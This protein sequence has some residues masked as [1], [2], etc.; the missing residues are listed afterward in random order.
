M[1]MIRR[2]LTLSA[3]VLAAVPL[4]TAARQQP[5]AKHT[6]NSSAMPCD[7]HGI[8]MGPMSG[9][10]D[11]HTGGM[12]T[13]SS[14]MAEMRSQLGLT[15]AQ[16]QQMRAIHQRACAA[17]EPHVKLAMQAH[18]A[19]MKALHADQPNLNGYREQT[20]TAAKH[21]VEAQVELAKGMIEFHKDLTTAQRQKMNQM[22]SRMMQG[23]R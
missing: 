6:Q 9:H 3:A 2:M 7:M 17:A 10:M 18:E 21:M 19:A 20:E 23:G 4:V 1:K 5:H 8:M 15:D 11:S 22:H 14:M 12:K 16:M 13:D